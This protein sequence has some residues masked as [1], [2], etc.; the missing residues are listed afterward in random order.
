MLGNTRVLLQVGGQDDVVKA[1]KSARVT[2]RVDSM[3]D[4]FEA[5]PNGDKRSDSRG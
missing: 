4:S 5:C 3:L 1:N 2:E